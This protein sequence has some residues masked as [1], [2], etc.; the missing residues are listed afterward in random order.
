MEKEYLLKL[1]ERLS[2]LSE[3]EKKLRNVY[4]SN[5]AKGLVQGPQLEYD[6]LNKNWLKYY[7][8]EQIMHDM[9][10]MSIYDYMMKNNLEHKD[11]C[12]INY[13]GKKITFGEFDKM[14]DDC[15]KSFKLNGVKPGDIVTICMPNTPEAVISF[16]ALNKIGAIAN[17]IHPLSAQ[18]EIKNF[19]NEVNSKMIIVIDIAYNK[20][21]NIADETKL[22][23]IVTVKAS[24]SMP[25]IKKYFYNIT[26]K[27][28]LIRDDRYV[29]WS[30][31]IKSSKMKKE[32]IEKIEYKKD[33]TS[34]ILHT[35]G[36][37]GIPKG[38]ELTDDNF[39]SMVEQFIISA[40]NFERKEKMLTI[41]PVFHGFGLCSSVHLP[42]SAGVTIILIPKFNS[43]KLD[44][45]L[46]KNK[47]NHIIG[48]PTLF[49]GMI[50]NKKLDKVDLS[51]IK[52]IVSG[53]DLVK[54]SL[55]TDINDFLRKHNS[56]AKLSK[57]YGLSEAVAGVTFA[58]DCYNKP[59]SIGIPMV[60][61][62]IKIVEPNTDNELKNGEIGEICVSGPTVMKKYYKNE[63]E[64]NN[65]IIA[66]NLHTGDMGYFDG[67]ILYYSQRKGDMIISSGVNVYPINI[68]KVIETHDAVASC[69]VIG[70]YH[71]YKIQVPKAYIVLKPGYELTKEL[72][73]EI[74]TLCRKNLN[75]YSI[76]YKYEFKDKLPET[77]L[78]K[79]SH[80][81]LEEENKIKILKK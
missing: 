71:P 73:D 38:V 4:L 47:P 68:E 17:M 51:F 67:E 40:S 24:D 72:I 77:L 6:S 20:V 80:K 52:Y 42:L 66:G 64:T 27:S 59:A 56:K 81:K 5:F 49:K 44:K 63:V 12:A 13:L 31:F 9:P 26:N 21:I 22:E 43:K 11:D 45:L 37:T 75:I 57:G 10:K 53:G 14:I 35:G 78:G 33:R 34:V 32:N 55:E 58:Y 36:T 41:M 16:Y 15:A 50:N 79:V 65:S 25:F 30:N 23:K 28:K 46:I 39:N 61:T 48:V 60:A 18:N 3:E 69:A 2:N 70:I 76:P 8:V 1:R 7:S 74:D 29:N 19:L 54:D 62:D